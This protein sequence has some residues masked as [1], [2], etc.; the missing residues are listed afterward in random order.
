MKNDEFPEIDAD[1]HCCSDS[2]CCTPRPSGPSRA[3]KT[4]A[5]SIVLLL[6]AGVSAYSLFWRDSDP[7]GAGC[8]AGVGCGSGCAIGTSIALLDQRLIGADFGLVVLSDTAGASII[9]ATIGEVAAR[10]MTTARQLKVI[11][12]TQQ[13]P[14]FPAVMSKYSVAAYPA[15]IALGGASSMVF[16]GEQITSEALWQIFQKFGSA[17]A[18]CCPADNPGKK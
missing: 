4:G 17:E 10:V 12:L 5:V 9:A 14:L 15:V 18:M 11:N 2:S 6:A 8:G 3:F 1:R 13:D 16:T 7:G